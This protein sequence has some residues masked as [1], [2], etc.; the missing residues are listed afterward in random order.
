MKSSE[1]LLTEVAKPPERPKPSGGRD[2]SDL[3]AWK[4]RFCF[5]KGFER[6]NESM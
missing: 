2:L 1:E 5:M 6:G 4:R 3:E